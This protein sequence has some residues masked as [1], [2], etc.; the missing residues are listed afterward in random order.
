MTIPSKHRYAH[1][2]SLKELRQEQTHLHY[3][4]LIAEKSME[5]KVVE[6]KYEL[7]PKRLLSHLWEPIFMWLTGVFTEKHA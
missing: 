1:I 2:T 5:L 7:D 6:L 3:K 4:V